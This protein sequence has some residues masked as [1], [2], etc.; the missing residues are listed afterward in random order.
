MHPY[1]PPAM[2]SERLPVH[3]DPIRCAEQGR[4]FKG[5]VK[6]SVMKRA[7]ELLVSDQGEVAVSLEGG[8]DLEGRPYLEGKLTTEVVMECQRC[9]EPVSYPIDTSFSLA[10]VEAEGE[11]ELLPSHYE[12][13]MME[14]HSLFLQEL[15]EDELILA[16]PAVALH[17]TGTCSPQWTGDN[18]EDEV[19]APPLVDEEQR[20]NP[21]AVLRDLKK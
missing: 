8:V 3:I 1:D 9:L 15:L 18:Q 12:P 17:P 5:D 14:G 7:L 10:P 6:L 19:E 16:L 13:L 2:V 11:I 20:E 4:V 21:F